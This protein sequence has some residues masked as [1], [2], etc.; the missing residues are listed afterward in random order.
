MHFPSSSSETRSWERSVSCQRA[1]DGLLFLREAHIWSKLEHGLALAEPVW[2]LNLKSWEVGNFGLGEQRI[3]SGSDPF[4]SSLLVYLFSPPRPPRPR[5]RRHSAPPSLSFAL[6]F[7]GARAMST[8]PGLGDAGV[9]AAGGEPATI[10][11]AY[12]INVVPSEL[13]LKFRKEV[14]GLRVGI[15]LEVSLFSSLSPCFYSL[16]RP[17][18]LNL[19]HFSSLLHF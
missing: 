19:S 4:R 7:F 18:K 10:D 8:R 12:N 11:E 13:F 2:S 17:G 14:E 16:R 9:D 3:L 6:S 15:N 1:N 5:P